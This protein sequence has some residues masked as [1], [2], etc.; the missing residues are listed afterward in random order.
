[1]HGTLA[2]EAYM[3]WTVVYDAAPRTAS[4]S[5]VS[6]VEGSARWW[7]YAVYGERHGLWHD[8]WHGGSS[9]QRAMQWTATICCSTVSTEYCAGSVYT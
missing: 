5:G 7:V 6:T 4:H 9:E 3:Q 2:I 8:P 1:M